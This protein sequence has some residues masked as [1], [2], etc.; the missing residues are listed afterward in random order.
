[1]TGWQRPAGYAPAPPPAVEYLVEV[2]GTEQHHLVV[3]RDVAVVYAQCRD[4]HEQHGGTRWVRARRH[5][6]HSGVLLALYDEHGW[7]A[8]IVCLLEPGVPLPPDDEP[9]LPGE[10]QDGLFA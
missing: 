1:M 7:P 4:L 5:D 9:V 8:G 3:T 6:P 10:G 2:L